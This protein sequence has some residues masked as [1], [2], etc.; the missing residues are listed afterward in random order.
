MSG[1]LFAPDLTNIEV[2]LELIGDR[3]LIRRGMGGPVVL[4]PA[5]TRHNSLA[6]EILASM[7]PFLVHAWIGAMQW[8]GKK[9]SY[10]YAHDPCGSWRLMTNDRAKTQCECGQRGKRRRIEVPWSGANRFNRPDGKRT[11]IRIDSE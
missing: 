2:F 1:A 9:A 11:L 7:Q 10:P 3:K 5:P 4:E 6:D 8:P